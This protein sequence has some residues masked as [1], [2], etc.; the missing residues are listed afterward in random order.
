MAFQTLTIRLPEE[1]FRRLQHAAEFTYRSLDDVVAATLSAAL[2][3]PPD[4]PPDLADELAAMNLMNDEALWAAAE[5][6]VS[7]AQGRR[8]RQLTHAGGARSLT[9]A[10]SAEMAHLLELRDRAILRRARALA[11]LSQRGHAIPD[12]VDFSESRDDD[13]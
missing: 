3:A 7:P 9:N 13:R 1:V 8:M 11:I 5:P 10:E 12:R 2:S 6:S 4:L